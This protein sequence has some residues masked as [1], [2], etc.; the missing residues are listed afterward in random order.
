MGFRS[1]RRKSDKHGPL[2][3]GV[4]DP[5]HRGDGILRFLSSN[6]IQIPLRLG[7]LWK[8]MNFGFV[9]ILQTEF[10]VGL[11]QVKAKTLSGVERVSQKPY[12]GLVSAVSLNQDQVSRVRGLT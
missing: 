5:T 8:G 3:I 11:A 12:L 2:F 9:T 6:R 1:Y 10:P 4:L 7:D